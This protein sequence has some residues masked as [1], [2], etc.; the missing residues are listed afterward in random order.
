MSRLVAELSKHTIFHII[1]IVSIC[2]IIIITVIIIRSLASEWGRYGMRF[3]VIA[4]GPIE[5]KV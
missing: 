1:I 2:T 4:P 5:T 3:N